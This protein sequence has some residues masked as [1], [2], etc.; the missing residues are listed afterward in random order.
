MRSPV[1]DERAK[2]A[3]PMRARALFT[4]SGLLFVL[5]PSRGAEAPPAGAP[6]S[7]SRPAAGGELA[8]DARLGVTVSLA[9]KDRPLGELLP[10]L[11]REIQVLLRAS[12]E[13]ADDKVTLFLA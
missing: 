8:E 13:V 3:S 2:E 10:A 6:V 7:P 11:G 4:V 1:L 5:S 9:Q 12:P